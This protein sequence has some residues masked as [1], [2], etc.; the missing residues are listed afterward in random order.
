MPHPTPKLTRTCTILAL[1]AL[2]SPLPALA[3]TD[4]AGCASFTSMVTVDPTA[5]GY[6]NVYPSVVYYVPDT[7]EI[8][9]A[10]DCGGGRAP[11][12]TGVPGCPLYSGTAAPGT[13]F[14]AAD[15]LAPAPTL[16][17]AEAQAPS[18]A[19]GVSPGTVTAAAAAETTG[20]VHAAGAT[21]SGEEEEA[22]V[23]VPEVSESESEAEAGSSTVTVRVATVTSTLGPVSVSPVGTPAG[24]GLGGVPHTNGTGST[25]VKGNGTGGVAGNGTGPPGKPLDTTASGNVLGVTMAGL[26]LALA[27]AAFVL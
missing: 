21:G 23:A 2:L 4:L 9:A 6:G 10:P 1:L 7:L 22:H 16:G 3:R 14:L 17:A 19:D 18:H 12:K 26:S 24:P 13:S 11:P 25:G 27:A 5:H 8:C 15:P 20:G